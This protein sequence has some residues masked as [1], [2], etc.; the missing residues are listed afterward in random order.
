MRR[1]LLPLSISVAFAAG[2]TLGTGRSST[3]GARPK[4]TCKDDLAKSRR[5]VA[6]ARTER[7]EARTERDQARAQLD[8]LLARERDRVRKL[9]EQIGEMAKDLK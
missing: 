3:A 4:T 8:E 1:I 6:A 2:W 9:E 5:D 7:D